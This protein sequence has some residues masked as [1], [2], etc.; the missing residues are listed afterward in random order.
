MSYLKGH[1]PRT[2]ATPQNEPIPGSSQVR[3]SAGGYAF[4]IDELGQ[5]DR[6]LILGAAGGSYY[7]SERKLT[8]D[9]LEVVTACLDKHG[10]DA[11]QRIVDVSLRGRAAKQQPTLVALAMACSHTDDETRKFAIKAIPSVCRT[12]TM[13]FEFLSFVKEYRGMGRGLRRGIGRWYTEASAQKLAYQLVKYRQRDGWTHRDVLR[14]AHPKAPSEAHANLFTWVTGHDDWV[15]DGEELEVV[16]GYIQAQMPDAELPVLIREYGL[17][18]EALP[19]DALKRADVW[20]ALLHAPMP[21]HA[22]VRNLGNLSKVGVLKEL[23]TDAEYVQSRLEDAAAVRKARLHPLQILVAAAQY[24]SGEGFRGSGSWTAVRT[25]VNALDSAFNASFETVEPTNKRILIG[26][27]VSASM[28]MGEVAGTRLTPRVAAAAMCSVIARTERQY[29]A[30]AFT[31]RLVPFELGAGDSLRDIVDRSS[32]FPHG[33]T[34]CAQPMLYAMQHG[35]E[36]DA[37]VIYTDNETWHGAIHPV[38]AL[39]M[40]RK[41]SGIDARLVVVGMTSTGFSI[42]DP[43]DAGMLD[44]VGFDTATPAIMSAFIRGEF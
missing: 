24:A 14:I 33:G 36:V 37:F 17:P 38:Q 29:A 42:A 32:R 25:V 40:Y 15:L 28:S 7:A 39:R 2:A 31:T 3:N 19:T 12:G 5:L 11:V 34:D 16:R 8:R 21:M 18:R 9:N 13:L 22:L 4:E 35:L 43:S 10:V 23:S 41:D 27:D 20:R 44:V 6:F 30:M 26:L 1:G